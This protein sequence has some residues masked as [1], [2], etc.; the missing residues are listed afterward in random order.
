MLPVEVIALTALG[1]NCGGPRHR[2]SK[3]AAGA[4]DDERPSKPGCA[5]AA[6]KAQNS[7]TYQR[8]FRLDA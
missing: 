4:R 6:D 3:G 8:A 5:K 2:R 1:F 7:S